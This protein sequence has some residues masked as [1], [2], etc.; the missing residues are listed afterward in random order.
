MAPEDRQ[1]CVDEAFERIEGTILPCIGLMLQDLLGAA[2]AGQAGVDPVVYADELRRLA[3]QL[4]ALTQEIEGANPQP[5]RKAS[6]SA[7]A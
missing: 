6:R 4:E 3:A 1:R 2:E 7:A 5:I